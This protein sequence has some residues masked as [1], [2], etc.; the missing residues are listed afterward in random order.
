MRPI[1]SQKIIFGSGCFWCTEAVF[2]RLRGIEKVES[3]YAGGHTDAPNYSTI[4]TQDIDHAEVIR[5]T[6]DSGIIPLERLLDVFFST[7]D[8]TTPNRQGNDIGSEYRSMILYTT[9]EQRHIY[10]NW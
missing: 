8:P 9:E 5:A 1:S 2:Q 3:G 6:F 7:H 10:K 4:H